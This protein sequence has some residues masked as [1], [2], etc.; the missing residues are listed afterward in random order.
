MNETNTEIEAGQTGAASAEPL[1]CPFCGQKP[2]VKYRRQSTPGYWV[3]CHNLQCLVLTGTQPH[4]TMRD[5]IDA[6]NQRALGY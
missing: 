5:A 3:G 2:A 6:W 4:P 1:D